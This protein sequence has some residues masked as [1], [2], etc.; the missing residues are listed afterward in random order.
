MFATRGYRT[1]AVVL[2][3]GLGLVACESTTASDVEAPE[4]LACTPNAVPGVFPNL[5]VRPGPAA[6]TTGSVP[7][8]QINPQV[9]PE[10]I[11]EMATRIFATAD[12]ESRPSTIVIGAT[13]IWM[14]DGVTLARPECIVSQREVGHIHQ[15]GSLHM[16]VPHGRIPGAVGAG[17]IEQHPFAASRPGFEAY[18]MIFTP[19]NSSEVDVI[20]ELV[21]DGVDFVKGTG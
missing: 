2:T 1:S 6:T 21:T 9:T 7:H 11:D 18:V 17:W 10:A 16:T 20:V 3:L 14:S 13:A 8:Q 12:V 4:R 19:R 15:D 5:P